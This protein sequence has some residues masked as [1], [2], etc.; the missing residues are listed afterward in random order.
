[1]TQIRSALEGQGAEY[2]LLETADGS[3]SYRFHCQVRLSDDASYTREFEAT[4]AE[5]VAAAERVLAEVSAWRTAS[6]EQKLR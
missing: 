3:A 6:R 4:A 2:I 1:L 5:P